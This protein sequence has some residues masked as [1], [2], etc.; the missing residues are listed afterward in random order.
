MSTTAITQPVR[1]RAF[2]LEGSAAWLHRGLAVALSLAGLALRL[3]LLGDKSLWLDEAFSLAISRRSALDVLRLTVFTDT[4]PPLYYLLMNVWLWF[5][6][7]EAYARLFSALWSAASIPLM[8]LLAQALFDDRRAGLLAATILAFSPFHIWYAQE[9]RMYAM[10]TFLLLASAYFFT[11]ALKRGA[12]PGAAIQDPQQRPG[13]V[14]DGICPAGFARFFLPV[15]GPAAWLDWAGFVFATTLALYTDN[16]ALWYAVAIGLFYLISIRRFKRSWLAWLL[17]QAAILALYMPWLPFFW[18]QTRRVIE[19]FWLPAP[20]FQV[21]LETLRDFTSL[22]LP[23]LTL[24]IVYMTAVLVWAYI[25]P[26]WL[27]WQRPLLTLWLMGPLVLSLLISTRQPIFLS[28][29]LIAASLGYYLL[30]AGAI[31]QFQGSRM[32]LAFLLPLLAMNLVSIGHNAWNEPKE[33]WRG[34]AVHVAQAVQAEPDGLVLF[35]PGFVELP[36]GYYFDRY[37]LEVDSHGYPQNE[38]LLHPEAEP[39]QD[40]GAVI[41]D[42]PRVWLVLRREAGEAP[43]PEVEG[44]LADNGYELTDEWVREAV[45]VRSFTRGEGTP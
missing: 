17:S 16:G 15:A 10:L 31:W 13:E 21:V 43:H 42:R 24:S 20:T 39:V 36:F 33:N 34:A 12:P 8:Y 9:T 2:P 7:S 28:R 18:I 40:I 6:A 41:D 25:L 22:N 44:W 35:I 14:C 29:N 32:T 5:G 26:N 38:T 45:I 27:G 3:Y 30:I 11:Q 1:L 37:D 19:S 23:W 4:H